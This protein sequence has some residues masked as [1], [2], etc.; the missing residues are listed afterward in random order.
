MIWPV[1]K[2]LVLLAFAFVF[3]AISIDQTLAQQVSDAAKTEKT[4]KRSA[5][6]VNG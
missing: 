5:A 2:T 4:G 3:A 6:L 1:K